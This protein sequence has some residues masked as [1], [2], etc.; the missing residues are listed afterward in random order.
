MT[1]DS[2]RSHQPDVPTED[3][4]PWLESLTHVLSECPAEFL[5]Q[6]RSDK[7]GRIDVAAIVCDHFRAMGRSPHGLVD[8][9]RLQPAG[10]PAAEN[11]LKM[12]SVATWLFHADGLIRRAELAGKMWSLLSEGL[13]QLSTV[14]RAE[15]VVTDP[16]RREEFVRLC[17]KQLGLRPKGETLLQAADRLTALDSV[18]RTAVVRQTREAE[19]RARK[20][21]QMMARRAAEEAAAKASR[22]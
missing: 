18:E 7:S 9:K 15:S 13:D 10:E 19:E 4:G 8:L 5:E 20:V 17:L 2:D 11:R 12:I 21:R 1:S 14:V 6:P 3:E 22:E 16:D